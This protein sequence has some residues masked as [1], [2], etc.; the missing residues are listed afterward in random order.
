M[1]HS[2]ETGDSCHGRNY[3]IAGCPLR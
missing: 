1:A 3:T 2:A